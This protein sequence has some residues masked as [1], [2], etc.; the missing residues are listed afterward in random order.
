[1]TK[2][3]ALVWVSAVSI[4]V[5]SFAVGG[6]T[7]FSFANKFYLEAI[8][9]DVNSDMV[10]ELSVLNELRKNNQEKAIQILESNMDINIM[11]LDSGNNLSSSRRDRIQ[12]A[13]A[14]VSEYRKKYQVINSDPQ[15][16][17]T[18]QSVLKSFK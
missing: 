12:K 3:K 9:S 11:L 2:T 6:Y 15:A 10:S 4:C 14:D 5:V 7:G 8:Y 16:E 1:M 17:E 13:I 18:I